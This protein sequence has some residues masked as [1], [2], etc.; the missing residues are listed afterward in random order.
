[1]IRIHP[2]WLPGLRLPDLT[3]PLATHC[4]WAARHHN[5]GAADQMV[6]MGGGSAF[7]APT[8]ATAAAAGDP[9]R[10]IAERYPGGL[11]EY[12]GL[13]Q[14]LA[15]R[16]VADRYLLPADEDRVVASCMERWNVAVSGRCYPPVPADAGAARL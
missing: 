11:D 15:K 10:S 14:V 3:A 8:A 2:D 13:V 16:L 4:G 1:M 7:F 12:A 9:R 5:T 6:P